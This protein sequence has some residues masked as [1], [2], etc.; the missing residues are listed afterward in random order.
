VQAVRVRTGPPNSLGTPSV[1]LP[2]GLALE[3]GK[4]PLIGGR[5]EEDTWL[6]IAYSQTATEFVP[7]EG[8]WVRKDMF[9]L[10][11]PVFIPE[12]TLTPTPT[13]TLTPTITSTFTIT[14]S[15]TGTATFTGTPTATDS[16]TATYTPFPTIEPEATNTP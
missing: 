6:M 3:V 5:N 2:S 9:D 11:T 14:V 8:G 4:C 10:S 13:I 12:V 1:A 16:A 15:P 7:F